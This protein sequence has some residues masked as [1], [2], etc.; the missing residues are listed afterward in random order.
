MAAVVRGNADGTDILLDRGANDIAVG[1]MVTEVNHF[2]AVA[3]Q[4]D[5]DGDDG[6]IGTSANRHY[7]QDAKRNLGRSGV[8]RASGPA[9]WFPAVED[10]PCARPRLVIGDW[11][12]VIGAS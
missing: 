10:K 9:H 5:V 6:A 7:R 4:F 3:Q 1:S 2:A 12:L 8:M 11:C